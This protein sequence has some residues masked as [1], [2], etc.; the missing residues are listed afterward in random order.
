MT[1]QRELSAKMLYTACREDQLPFNSTV[2][3]D[4]SDEIVGQERALSAIQFGTRI[5]GNGYNI[6]ALGSPGTGKFTALRHILTAE[7]EHKPTP[8]DWCYVH[9]FEQPHKPSALELP[10]GHGVTLRNDMDQLIEDLSSAIPAAFETEDYHAQIEKLEQEFVE[11][12][13]SALNKLAED[14]KAHRVQLVHT[15]TGFAFAPLDEQDRVIRP[16]QFDK[17]ADS[18]KKQIEETITDLQRKM[19]R[20]IR[21]FPMRQKETREKIRGLDREIA[22][23]SVR[24]L[25][26]TIKEK[27]KDLPEVLKYLDAVEQDIVE[28]VKEF[29]TEHETPGL[30][31]GGGTRAAALQRYKVNL[32]VDHR[33]RRSAP[34]VDQDLPSHTNLMGRTEYQSQMGTLVTDFTLIKAGDLHRANGGYLMLDAR[35]LLI[36]PYAWESLKRALRSSEI[37]IEPLERTIGLISTISLEPEPIP[38]NVKV[39]LVGDRLLYYLLNLYDPEFREL[40]KVAADF[41][42]TLDRTELATNAFARAI[43]R[44]A[45]KENLQ[46]LDRSGVARIIEHC[47]RLAGDSEKLSIHL[48]SIRDLLRESDYWAREDKRDTITSNHVQHAIDKQIYRSD[49]VRKHVYEAIERGI[50]SIDVVGKHVGQINGLS[51]IDLGDFS[52]GQPSRITATTRLGAGKV[53][54]IER[55]SE[56]GGKIHSKGVLILSNFLASRYAKDKPLSLAASLVFEQSYGMVEGDSA[57]LA[58]LCAL[59]SALADLPIRQ[60]LAVTGSINQLG[61]VQAIGGVNQ[62]V[63]GFFDVCAARGSSDEQ[64]VLIPSANVRHL[65]L[66]EDVISAVEKG[67]FH[68]FAVETVDQAIELLTGVNAGIRDDR[69]EFPAD[70]VNGRVE[71]CLTKLAA[72]RQRFG[73]DSAK[74]ESREQE[75]QTDG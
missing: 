75:S 53:V 67:Q 25:I 5:A 18:E 22:R 64:G 30:F 74:D 37:R 14:A 23:Y 56:L 55:E 4:A 1:T 11:E 24:H 19:Q 13:D 63:E 43:A 35:R 31:G 70:S 73:Q 52:F 7:A 61:H 29:R 27:H 8:S 47:A 69:I 6:F 12:R 39:V 65:M 2:E 44:I 38:L 20:I 51:V 33:H 15:P 32:I 49:R 46:P 41:E 40:F 57:S 9:N 60:C 10:P 59:L 16:E 72:L 28:H 50:I 48:R 54:D 71:K 45:T 3:V 66:R 68:V 21:Q 34:V 26:D 58:E 62:K 36:Q 42:E 17:L